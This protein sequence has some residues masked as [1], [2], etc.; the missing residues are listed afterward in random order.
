MFGNMPV[1]GLRPLLP[2]VRHIH[3][4]FYQVTPEG[5]EPNIPYPQ[6]FALLKESGY[7][8]TISAEWEGHA[9]SAELQGFE[10]VAAWHAMCAR[11]REN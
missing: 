2:Y 6:I 7:S 10:Q 5:V 1:E 9:F 3:G 11:L 8:G 4:K